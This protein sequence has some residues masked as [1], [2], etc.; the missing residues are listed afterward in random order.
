MRF[1]VYK[2]HLYCFTKNKPNLK[3]KCIWIRSAILLK[4][5]RLP[6]CEPGACLVLWVIQQLIIH[7]F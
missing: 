4:P 1:L 3:K 5:K 7:H 6:L 2:D